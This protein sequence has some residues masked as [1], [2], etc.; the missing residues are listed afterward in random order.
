M[1][2]AREYHERTNHTPERL[3]SSSHRM[4]EE[5][6]PRP[7]KRYRDVSSEPLD[8][9]TPPHQPALATIAQARP[10]SVDTGSQGSVLDR[11]TVATCCYLAAGITQETEYKGQSV[12]FRAASCTGN[13]HH[14]D[15]Y[16]IAGGID[17][18][19][20]GVYHF[21]PTA[22]QLDRLRRGDVRATVVDATGGHTPDAGL[23]L[24]ATSTWWRNAWKY[25]ERTYR[26]AFW[27]GGTVLANLLA[28]AHGL[29][30]RAEIVAAY[31]DDAIADLIGVD[32]TE[33][34]PIAA[35]SIGR[36]TT[37]DASPDVDPIEPETI[38]LSTDHID[39]PLIPEA[40]AQSTLADG[41]A[42]QAWRNRCH[43]AGSL[44]LAGAGD[45]EQTALEPVDHA[46]ASA[47]PL[48]ET[49]QRRGSKRHFAP[50]GPTRRQL[51]T[52][53]DRATRGIPADWA[54]SS[55]G[56]RYLDC[57]V[58]ATSVRG[59][60]DGTYH[61][62]PEIDEVEWLGPIDTETKAELAL[63]QEWGGEAHVNVYLLADVDEI[64]GTL[65]NRG[66]RLAQLEAGI[67]LGRLY[68]ATAAHRELGG[69]GL[70]FFDG[71]VRDHFA[72]RAKHQSPM[73]MFAMGR[74]D[75]EAGP[76]L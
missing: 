29:D 27:D 9:I 14:I 18:L 75:P 19:T 43:E 50:E 38:P 46:T 40:W 63:G 57:Y 20:D 68:L 41:S 61:Y 10:M 28:A 42:A 74:I 65:G 54:S 66:Y 45:G 1:V 13:L 32:P 24:V 31:A 34:A 6:K 21:D 47:R 5:I 62:H 69:T 70:T 8:T 55:T 7:F 11:T 36:G 44:G 39:F 35:V 53:L 23:W 22:F 73:T 4:I 51:G 59:L 33:E 49:I 25:Q 2:D 15:L 17:G 3:R 64:V 60:D 26:H 48:F 52:V 37:P 12:R 30:L 72:P 67:T 76:R 58:L 71:A 56:L 16:L